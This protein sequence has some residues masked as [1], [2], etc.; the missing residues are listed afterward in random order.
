MTSTGLL[1]SL[2]SFLWQHRVEI[3]VSV[4]FM[5]LIVGLLVWLGGGVEGAPWSYSFY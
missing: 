4:L 2:R 5:A 3:G 1:P